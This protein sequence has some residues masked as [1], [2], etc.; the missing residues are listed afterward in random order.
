[1]DFP[2]PF[3][4]AVA[5]EYRTPAILW[6][7]AHLETPVWLTW[8]SGDN[9]G[10][11]GG[12]SVKLPKT[13]TSHPNCTSGQGPHD[14]ARA[15]QRVR[16]RSGFGGAALGAVSALGEILSG[17]RRCAGYQPRFRAGAL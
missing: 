6:S 12:V 13:A 7:I 14:L 5:K 16:Q 3:A 11:R 9:H 2:L 1:M 10:G 4:A 8:S 17:A 15:G